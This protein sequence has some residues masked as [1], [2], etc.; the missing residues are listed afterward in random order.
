[1]SDFFNVIDNVVI[2]LDNWHIFGQISIWRILL[3]CI[4]I[5]IV[6]KLLKSSK[7]G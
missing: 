2:F 4:V 1:M 6:G 3:V 5:T 7:G